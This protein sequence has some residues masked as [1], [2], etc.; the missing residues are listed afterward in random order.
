MREFQQFSGRISWWLPQLQVQ[1]ECQ[2]VQI[3]PPITPLILSSRLSGGEPQCPAEAL[4]V[5]ERY[6]PNLRP[7]TPHLLMLNISPR[8][9]SLYFVYIT[10]LLKNV[11][12]CI[13]RYLFL[14]KYLWLR[15][16][17]RLKPF[18]EDPQLKFFWFICR[19]E[20]TQ[21]CSYSILTVEISFLH[22]R[23]HLSLALK[24]HLL[25]RVLSRFRIRLLRVCLAFRF[26]HSSRLSQPRNLCLVAPLQTLEC[27]EGRG[28]RFD[29]NRTMKRTWSN[30][31]QTEVYLGPLLF[32]LSLSLSPSHP[33]TTAPPSLQCR[34][35]EAG[36]FKK[37]WM[38]RQWLREYRGERF[39]EG[40]REWGK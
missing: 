33:P 7:P 19:S 20:F 9:T 8:P 35:N 15:S 13:K 36:Q 23:K 3:P 39:G 22:P 10:L 40:K 12:D 2:Q 38:S 14:I 37:L 21:R 31:F 26:G 5:I 4:S 17:W 16:S 27:Q 1:K 28:D 6:D 30:Y 25:S 24:T 34:H 29:S 11:L 18:R 32:T